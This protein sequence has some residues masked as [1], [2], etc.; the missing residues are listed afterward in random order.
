MHDVYG[1]DIETDTTVDGFEMTFGV[2]H[3]GHF[4]LTRRLHGLVAAAPTPRVIVLSSVAHWFTPGGLNF[5]DLQMLRFY[6]VWVAYGRS[7]LANMLFADELARRWRG[8]GVCVSSV[9]PGVVRSGFGS[10]GDTH[11]AAGGLIEFSKPFSVPPDRGAD[12]SLWLATSS[13]GVDLERSGTFWSNRKPGLRAPW[14]RRKVDAARLWAESEE[15]VD[16]VTPR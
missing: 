13:V 1:L 4:E 10:D 7:K 15:L 5:D 6:N 11:G 3:L 9:H 14:A 16:S 12:T 2:N 8:D